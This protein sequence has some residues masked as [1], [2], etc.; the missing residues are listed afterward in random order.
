MHKQLF[1]IS[2]GHLGL[3]YKTRSHALTLMA[4]YTPQTTVSEDR[5]TKTTKTTK[6]PMWSILFAL[7][8]NMSKQFTID[9]NTRCETKTKELTIQKQ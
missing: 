3:S 7:H 5:E 2:S 9:V 8:K 4:V 1:T 6:D